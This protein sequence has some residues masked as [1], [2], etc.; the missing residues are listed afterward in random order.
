MVIIHDTTRLNFPTKIIFI[1]IE[2]LVSEKA[3]IDD[4][5]RS[6]YIKIKLFE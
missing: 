4:E 2:I 1:N 3:L 6:S 5:I